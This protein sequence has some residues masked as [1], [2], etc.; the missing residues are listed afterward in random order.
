MSERGAMACTVLLL[1][2]ASASGVFAA[3]PCPAT[4]PTKARF[5]TV[6]W[7]NTT[8]R[9]DANGL[10]GHQ[11]LYVQRGDRTPVIVSQRATGPAPDPGLCRL[12]GTL[13][14]G[15]QSVLA[16]TYTRLAVSPDGTRVAFELND[17]FSILDAERLPDD[18]K[19]LYLARA[20][21]SDVVRLAPATA[22]SVFQL[23][24]SGVDFGNNLRFSPDGRHLV[25]TDLGPAT[26]G[27]IENQL[28]SLRIADGRRL[29]LTRL[30]GLPDADEPLRLEYQFD[31]SDP[32]TI[33]FYTFDFARNVGAPRQ[34]F[35]SVSID[36]KKLRK[37][38]PILGPAGQ[39]I[40]Q[41][42][43]TGRR[44]AVQ[45]LFVDGTAE[46]PMLSIRRPRE[47][48]VAFGGN[49]LQLTHFN[50]V[51]VGNLPSAVSRNGERVFFSAS[52][53]PFGC[54]PTHN[55]QVF[56]ID[57]LGRRLRQLTGFVEGDRSEDGCFFTPSP[58][59]SVTIVAQ[60]RATG[61]LIVDSSCDSL[62]TNP[63]ANQLFALHPDGSGLR[64]ITHARGVVTDTPDVV[65]VELPGPFAYQ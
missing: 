46:N 52:A 59:C 47:L 39:V 18:Q 9:T 44:P 43:L 48:F 27:T 5:R 31:F 8:C 6:A 29:Q 26:D 42:A 64:Q 22:V 16:G 28:W 20:D 40:A 33:G 41:F 25:Y 53:D 11:E 7:V 50:R 51:D 37:L 57:T 13:R 17:T 63:S 62:G 2:A 55:C 65:E 19:G 12:Y 21:G 4:K 61:T 30:A 34:E 24:P 32:T 38:S 56:S 35:Y 3:S 60:D 54:N 15:P 10:V 36:G 49:V 58:G 14:N 45:G 1:L 23:V